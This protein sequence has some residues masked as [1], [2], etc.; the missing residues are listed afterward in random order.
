M[1]MLLRTVSWALISIASIAFVFP[2]INHNA[3]SLQAAPSWEDREAMFWRWMYDRFDLSKPKD[4]ESDSWRN[5]TGTDYE[6]Y[7]L[8]TIV[9]R[10][11]E[12]EF[13]TAEVSSLKGDFPPASIRSELSRVVLHE[14]ATGRGSMRIIDASVRCTRKLRTDELHFKLIVELS[15]NEEVRVVHSCVAVREFRNQFDGL[16]H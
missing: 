7:E 9:Y 8:L 6:K 16:K 13:K 2:R 15:S 5:L 4:M 1:F 11:V 12:E 10:I 14:P 3:H